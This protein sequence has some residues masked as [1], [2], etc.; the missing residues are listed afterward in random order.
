MPKNVDSKE[1]GEPYL[2]TLLNRFNL[3]I[4][5]GLAKTKNYTISI[6]KILLY[7]TDGGTSEEILD[8]DKFNV[9]SV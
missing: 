7:K 8:K 3:S 1:D 2:K 5:N 9:N 4:N 6:D